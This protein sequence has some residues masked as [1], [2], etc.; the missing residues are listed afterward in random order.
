MD[1][2]NILGLA[3]KLRTEADAYLFLE[4]LR[5]GDQPVCPHCGSVR[6]HYFLT[7]ERR[8]AQDPHRS[9]SQRRVW[10]CADCRKQF[11]VLTG[12]IFHGTKIPVRTWLFVDLRN[13]RLQER[14]LRPARSSAST[15]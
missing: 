14:R 13:V 3:D 10:K 2:V 6:K 11:S 5:W 15:T 12:T 4:E 7:P 9:A 1:Q 8:V